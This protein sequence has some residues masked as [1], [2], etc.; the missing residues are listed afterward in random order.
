MFKNLSLQG[1]KDNS[2]DKGKTH[3]II[4]GRNITMKGVSQQLALIPIV[5]GEPQYDR[6]RVAKPGDNDIEFEEDV[7]AVLEMPYA[8]LG[9]YDPLDIYGIPLGSE[10]QNSIMPFTIDDGITPMTQYNASMGNILPD[11]QISGTFEKHTPKKSFGQQY[12]NTPSLITPET[13]NQLNNLSINTKYGFSDF[14][15][16]LAFNESLQNFQNFKLNPELDTDTL[17]TLRAQREQ[18]EEAEK[19]KTKIAK[20]NAPF[21]GAINPYGGWNM[22]N[23]ST[24]FGAFAGFKPDKDSKHY[25]RQK[26]GKTLGM[27]ASAGKVLLEGARNA[28]ASAG[29]MNIYQSSLDDI[30]KERNRYF[31]NQGVNYMQKGGDVKNKEGLLATGNFIMGNEEHPDPNVEVE[32]G[33]HLQTPDGNV[34]EV[35]GKKHSQGG[36]LLNLPHSTIVVSDYLKIGTKLATY[37]KKNYDLNVTAKNTYATVIDKY[38]RKIGLEKV[39]DE[40]TKILQKMIDQEDIEFQGTKD[41]NLQVLSERANEIQIQKEPLEKRLQEFTRVVYD[42]QEESKDKKVESNEKQQGGEI[43]PEEQNQPTMDAS[44]LEQLVMIYCQITNQDPEQVIASLQQMPEDRL[45]DAISQMVSVVQQQGGGDNPQEEMMEGSMSNPQEEQAEQMR[46]GGYIPYNSRMYMQPGGEVP[47][48]MSKDGVEYYIYGEGN[49]TRMVPKTAV[50]NDPNSPYRNNTWDDAQFSSE[51]QQAIKQQAQ[52]R[53]N[54][55]PVNT[56]NLDKA[57]RQ[58]MQQVLIDAGYDIG[59]TGAD[60]IIGSKTQAAMRK[61]K[62]EDPGAY[63]SWINAEIPEVTVSRK[64]PVRTQEVAVSTT[65]QPVKTETQSAQKPTARVSNVTPKPQVS[66]VVASGVTTTTPV[67]TVSNGRTFI[68]NSSD[69]GKTTVPVSSGNAYNRNTNLITYEGKRY[70]P[71]QFKT[72][73][74][75][76]EDNPVTNAA[77]APNE[78]LKVLNDALYYNKKPFFKS[79]IQG[80]DGYGE[81]NSAGYYHQYQTGGQVEIPQEILDKLQLAIDNGDITEEEAMQYVAELQGNTQMRRGGWLNNPTPFNSNFYSKD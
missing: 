55:D 36:E 66:N 65:R 38:K 2:P 59:K 13:Q 60:G 49:N 58:R 28:F 29:A 35:V 32:K 43:T 69:A 14:G 11:M 8:Q 7:E 5:G 77:G 31:L 25:D 20:E 27:I 80:R 67:K 57:E 34:M 48:T 3:N 74:Q 75:A 73:V 41:L 22:Q 4:P 23:A 71:Y 42:K 63:K 10:N 39:L 37:F 15:K 45:Q 61:F 79:R 46:K 1:Y 64:Q 12:G 50:D 51:N 19:V 68:G 6:R 17:Q 21:R 81:K 26:A 53:F 72:M 18:K 62:E 47:K 24:A 56:K 78:M 76:I 40:E 9:L 16:K 54:S 70:T 44:Q 33:E 52:T 30:D